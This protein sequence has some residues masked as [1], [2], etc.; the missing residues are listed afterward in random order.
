MF[1]DARIPMGMMFSIIG[2]ILTALGMATR[3]NA[4]VYEKCFAIDA[5]LWWGAV[6]L[7]S[8]IVMLFLG[9]I[10]QSRLEKQRK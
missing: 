3:G 1:F 9:R 4:Q 5:N 6:L 2:T 10:G 8:G 7:L